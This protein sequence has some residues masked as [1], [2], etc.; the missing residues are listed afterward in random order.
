[1]LTVRKFIWSTPTCPHKIFT[2]RLPGLVQSYARMTTRLIALVPFLGLVA[3]GQMGTRLADRVGIATA[4]S[5]LLRQLMQLPAPVRRTVRVLGIDDFAWKKRFTSGTIFVDLER[6][7]IIDVLADRESAT[8]EA[9][10][11]K[12]PEVELV[13]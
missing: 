5:T 8:V 11:Q 12:H 7:K 3:G 2:E 1:M 10:L 13:I 6:R 9:W 4:S